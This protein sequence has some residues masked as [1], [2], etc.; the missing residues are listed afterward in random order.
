MPPRPSFS[1]MQYCEM[2]WPIT[3]EGRF[4]SD[5][6]T[7][8]SC[9]KSMLAGKAELNPSNVLWISRRALSYCIPP[10][11]MWS[12][13]GLR[14]GRFFTELSSRQVWIGQHE[15]THQCIQIVTGLERNRQRR[16]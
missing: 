10:R 11:Y 8:P 7:E 2:V 16:H 6:I 3:E 13:L 9:G 5:H 4:A 1:M 14:S 15:V 12:T